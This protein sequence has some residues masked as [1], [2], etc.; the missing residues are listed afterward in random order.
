MATKVYLQ[1]FLNELPVRLR[2]KGEGFCRR[3][4]QAPAPVSVLTVRLLQVVVVTLLVLL[5]V[6]VVRSASTA[7]DNGE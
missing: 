3:Q 6:G 1:Y 5:A 7:T 4:N 2:K